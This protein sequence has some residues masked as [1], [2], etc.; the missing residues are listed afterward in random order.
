MSTL[1]EPSLRDM[2]FAFADLQYRQELHDR[3]FHTDIYTLNKHHRLVH[4]VLHQCKYVAHLHTTIREYGI[5]GEL[6]IHDNNRRRL[7]ILVV[8]GFIVAFSMMNTCN[9]QFEEFMSSEGW[10]G[11][12]PLNLLIR[13]VGILAKAIEDVDHMGQKNPL[14]TVIES[15]EVMMA[16]YYELWKQV[17]GDFRYLMKRIYDRLIEVEKKNIFYSY[18]EAEMKALILKGR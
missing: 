4:L 1:P 7:E 5:V 3:L 17:G 15:V 8:D 14:K 6:N 13:H 18:H 9:Y 11:D 16:A 12:A 10:D 2:S